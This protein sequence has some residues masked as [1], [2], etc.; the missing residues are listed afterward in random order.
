MAQGIK[1]AI[2]NEKHRAIIK[3][4]NA[5]D[6]L[7]TILAKHSISRP[8]YH[9]IKKRY[10]DQLNEGLP[11]E[12]TENSVAKYSSELLNKSKYVALKLANTLVN[13]N[14]TGASISQLTTSLVNVNQMVRLEEGKSTENIAHKVLHN[15]DESQLELLRSSIA[16]MKKS[17]L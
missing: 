13:R 4:I 12:I 3:S 14:M 5:G 7:Q 16:D 11:I 17:L 15:L 2:A 1:P 6:D 9:R 8:S 10:K